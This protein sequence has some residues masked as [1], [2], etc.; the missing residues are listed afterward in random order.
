MVERIT[1]RDSVRTLGEDVLDEKAEGADAPPQQPI[2]PLPAEHPWKYKGPALA[3]VLFLNCACYWFSASLGP[4]KTTLKK[5]LKIDNAQYGVITSSGNLVNTV[6]PLISGIMI[7]YYGPEWLSLG[8]S[9]LILVGAIIS[10]AGA[11]V[12][13][14]AALVSGEVYTNWAHGSHLGLI[15]GLNNAVNRVI[16]VNIGYVYFESQIP[17]HLRALTGR[18]A[19]RLHGGG[20]FKIELRKSWAAVSDLPAVFWLFTL[21]QILQNATVQ[22]YVSLQADMITQTRGSGLLS[23]GYISAVAQVPVI[24]LAPLTGYFMDRFGYRMHFV[25]VSAAFFILIFALTGFSNANAVALLP[26]LVPTLAHI[27]TAQGTY[28]AFINSGHVIIVTSAGVIQDLTPT[29]KHSY[30]NV[31]YFFMAIKVVDF[32]LGIFYIV[33]DR[34]ALDSILTRSEAAQ[35]KHDLAVLA[36]EKVERVSGLRK[37]SKAWTWAGLATGSAMTVA[38]W[39]IYLVYAQGS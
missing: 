20:G 37:P 8:S 12:K 18:Q 38:A 17:Q 35:A 30:S 11:S 29:G 5:E 7:D 19:S 21:S 10:G 15:Y 26:L 4:L 32:L 25:P 34:V 3:M 24:V 2:I 1:T 22:G 23:A 9:T 31:L 36:G 13:S 28:Q 14:Y 6:V 27:G 16:V 39:T 33:L